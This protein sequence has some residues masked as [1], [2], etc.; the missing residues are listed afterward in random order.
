MSSFR[1][2]QNF[3]K[4]IHAGFRDYFRK[5]YSQLHLLIPFVLFFFFFRRMRRTGTTHA[6]VH[7]NRLYKEAICMYRS[8]AIR[9][10]SIFETVTIPVVLFDYFLF[11]PNSLGKLT[12]AR[13][14]YAVFFTKQVIRIFFSFFNNN[15]KMTTRM[16]A[17]PTSRRRYSLFLFKKILEILNY[18]ATTQNHTA[19]LA[20]F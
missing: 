6:F 10:D 15:L 3:C 2:L 16:Y 20:K 11:S 4:N 8:T 17:C 19:S 13:Y 7:S 9:G 14:F 1:V 18:F 12:F 5:P